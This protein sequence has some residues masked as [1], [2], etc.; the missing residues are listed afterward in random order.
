MLVPEFACCSLEDFVGF[1]G[2]KV[3]DMSKERGWYEGKGG[4]EGGEG[5]GGRGV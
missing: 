1:S 4:T 2:H 5:E 3:D